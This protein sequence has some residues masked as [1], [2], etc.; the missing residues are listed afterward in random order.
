MALS[1][2][3][4]VGMFLISMLITIPL[5]YGM[6]VLMPFEDLINATNVEMVVS[7]Q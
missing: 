4:S 6:N 5:T 3:C 2:M 7:G 1:I